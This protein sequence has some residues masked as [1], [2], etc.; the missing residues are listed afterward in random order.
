MSAIRG[1]P[2]H[3]FWPDDLSIADAGFF[4]PELLSSHSRV[5]DSYL[6][7]LTHTKGGRLAT[8]D[9]K[10]AAEV[11][12]GGKKALGFINRTDALPFVRRQGTRRHHEGTSSRHWS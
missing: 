1:P 3:R 6:L 10:L 2:G 7:A 5:T 4:A 12:Q 8:M 9:R 11:V